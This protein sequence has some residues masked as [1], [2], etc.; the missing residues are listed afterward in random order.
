MKKPSLK[1]ILLVAVTLGI[2]VASCAI[3]ALY[4]YKKHS[5]FVYQQQYIQQIEEDADSITQEDD[6]L[7]TVEDTILASVWLSAPRCGVFDH[8]NEVDWN[9]RRKMNQLNMRLARHGHPD[10][11]PILLDMLRVLQ[12][13]DH[14]KQPETNEDFPVSISAYYIG[15]LADERYI[16]ELLEWVTDLAVVRYDAVTLSIAVEML[17]R[18][19]PIPDTLADELFKLPVLAS[20]EPWQKEEQ[21]IYYTGFYCISGSP[22]FDKH[23]NRYERINKDRFPSF[24]KSDYYA[25]AVLRHI[26]SNKSSKTPNKILHAATSL[27][28]AK[29]KDGWPVRGR[30]AELGYDRALLDNLQQHYRNRYHPNW[31]FPD[32]KS[33]EKQ[34]DAQ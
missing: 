30:P 6:Y 3:Y 4:T 33:G 8:N 19:V 11:V 26:E 16:P 27:F 34:S 28:A 31:P 17:D 29:N 15:L 20:P 23:L 22:N 5:Y 32:E 25:N 13:F 24:L 7:F 1:K 10:A 18:G 12:H 21:S 9:S 14:Q 2:G